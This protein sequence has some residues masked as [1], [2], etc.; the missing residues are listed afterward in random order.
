MVLV[1]VVAIATIG[2]GLY[3]YMNMKKALVVTPVPVIQPIQPATPDT[4]TWTTYTNADLGYS[5]KYPSSWTFDEN[6]PKGTSFYIKKEEFMPGIFITVSSLTTPEQDRGSDYIKYGKTTHILVDNLDALL[7]TGIPGVAEQEW[8]FINKN[9]KTYILYALLGSHNEL[10]VFRQTL[11]TFRFLNYNQIGADIPP[12]YPGITWEA[13]Q[14]GKFEF[15]DSQSNPIQLNGYSNQS[16]VLGP[17][18]RI[19]TSV[20]A[21]ALNKIETELRHYYEQVLPVRGWQPYGGA[22]SDAP[23]GF[24]SSWG[25]QKGDRYLQ[26]EYGYDC[27]DHPDG[28]G[29]RAHI[30]YSTTD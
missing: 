25:Y 11:S 23:M 20:E 18:S 1:A 21:I 7:I 12:L 6:D 24:G 30:W 28:W 29:L 15:R 9:N 16:V 13:T 17:C 26:L 4:S 3:W 22:D 2:G 5:L 10:N 19:Q 27:N 8:V 14:S